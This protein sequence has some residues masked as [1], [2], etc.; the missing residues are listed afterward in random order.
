MGAYDTGNALRSLGIAVLVAIVIAGIFV[1][2]FRKRGIWNK[3][4]LKDQLTTEK[5]YVP[6]QSREKWIGQ[7]GMSTSLLRPSGTADIG[8]NRLDVITSGE[9]VERGTRVRVVSVDGTRIVVKEI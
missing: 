2:I 1:Y 8:G 5:G 3:F 6:Q 4:I 7:E 9:F